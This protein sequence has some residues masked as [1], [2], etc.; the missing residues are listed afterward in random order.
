VAA[1]RDGDQLGRLLRDAVAHPGPTAVRFPKA[2]VGATVPAIGQLGGADLLAAGGEDVLIV[3]V[4]GLAAAAVSAAGRLAADGVRSSVVDPGWVLPVHPALVEAA[5]RYRRVVT[6][7][8]GGSH[9]GYGD[10]FARAAR[11]G[12]LAAAVHALALPQRFL[13]HGPRGAILAEHGLDADGIA[14][15]VRR[16]AGN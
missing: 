10:A 2:D 15:A 7:E 5:A 16:F 13:P 12:G 8:D 1:P 3:A 9:G 11:I 14:T 6:V 4:G